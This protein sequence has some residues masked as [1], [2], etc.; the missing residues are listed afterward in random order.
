MNMTTALAAVT[1]INQ[2]KHD[3]SVM[4]ARAAATT[5]AIVVIMSKITVTTARIRRGSSAKGLRV[6][7]SEVG[8][9]LIQDDR[10]SSGLQPKVFLEDVR[11]KVFLEAVR[12]LRG[13]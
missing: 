6:Q 10:S 2:N 1:G 3:S 13:F 9:F 5:T 12:G 11:G 4:T 8:K 7:I